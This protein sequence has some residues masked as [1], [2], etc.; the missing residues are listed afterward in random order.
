MPETSAH[1]LEPLL[2]AAVGA[3]SAGPPAA[4]LPLFISILVP[5]RNEAKCIE[6]T[7]RGLLAQEYD[8]ARFEIL[9]LDGESTDGT[10]EIVAGLAE[11]HANLRLSNN[12]R[13]LSSAARN[14]GI[15][16][17]RG[18]V[19]LIIDGHCE[20][21]DR[22]HLERLAAA[23]Q[24]SG[25]D[26]VARP[27]PLDVRDA[28]AL[29]RA[30]AAARSSRLGHHPE[31]LVYAA[32]EAFVP[33]QSA[34]VAYR[35]AIFEQIGYFDERFDACEDVEFNY[36][37]DRAGL[38]CF[39]TPAVAV[40]YAPR[41]SLCG[42]YR[43]LARYGRGRIRLLRKH[44]GTFSPVSM[45]PLVFVIGLLAGGLASLVWT[46]IAV[47]YAAGL[48]LYAAIVLGASATIA[49]RQG[50]PS[51]LALLPPV[52]AT[53]HVASGAGMAIELA[54]RGPRRA[55]IEDGG[56]QHALGA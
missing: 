24:R 55:G 4:A 26:A 33:A 18:D 19:V 43:Q 17:A 1:P 41:D 36:R 16:N 45:I 21:D 2:T 15:R 8:P 31:S 22:R 44:P 52:F 12:A 42:L 54:R 39:F 28:T 32:A 51:L 40:A 29:Q 37:L 11:Q 9:V 34:A 49:L 47:A 53:I 10:P 6:R 38:R 56:S 20:V 25:A 13:R 5:V 48:T 14:V 50:Q 27:Q 35:R 3:R 30:I 46:W 23:F 7:L